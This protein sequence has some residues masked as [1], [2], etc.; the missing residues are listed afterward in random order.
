M[1]TSIRDLKKEVKYMFGDLV[2]QVLLLNMAADKPDEKNHKL[3]DE[4][5]NTYE[6]ILTKINAHRKEK[7]KKAYF[8][9]L[10]AEIDE[11]FRAFQEKINAL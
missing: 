8:K 1:A 11:K 3:I 2:E 6:E 10:N 7:D 5:V 9:A 4:I